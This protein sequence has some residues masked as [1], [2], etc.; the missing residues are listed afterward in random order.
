MSLTILS[1]CGDLGAVAL[2]AALAPL[3][4]LGGDG[5]VGLQLLR[6][7]GSR[8]GRGRGGRAASRQGAQ[9]RVLMKAPVPDPVGLE[10]VRVRRVRVRRTVCVWGPRVSG[11]LGSVAQL[12]AGLRPTRLGVMEGRRSGRG[13]G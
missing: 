5:R 8:G 7:P 3:A 6:V 12:A 9:R 10:G 11:G 2:G 4:A 13:L 1:L